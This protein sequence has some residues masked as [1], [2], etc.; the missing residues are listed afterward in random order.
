M[1]RKY[2]CLIVVF[3]YSTAAFS[4]QLETTVVQ[5]GNEKIS[6]EE[7][8]LRFELSPYIPSDRNLDPDSIKYDFLYSLIAEKLWA[9]EAEDIGVTSTDKFNFIFKPLEDMFVRDALFKIE[10][11]DKVSLSAEDI[12]NGNL[13]SQT[14]LNAQI[15]TSNDSLSIFNLYQKLN[16]NINF[17][18]L[19]S[20]TNN[21]TRNIFDVSLG[22]LKD[23]AIEDSLYSLPLNGFTSPIKSEVGWVIFIIKNKIFT[24]IDLGNQQ[25]VDN[26]KKVIRNRRIEKR[27]KEYLNELL[28][29]ITINIDPEAFNLLN[30]KVWNVLKNKSAP[31]DSA[32]YFEISESDFSYIISSLGSDN[33]D[34]QLFILSD[35]EVI[36]KDFLSRLAFNGF[37]VTQLDS[38]VVL[39][40]LNQRVKRFVEEQLITEEAF[41]SGLQHTPQVRNDLQIW[42]ENYLAQLYF[43]NNLDSIKITDND[44]YNYYI[45]ELVNASNIRLLNIRLV[46]INDLDEV[47]NIFDLLKEGKDFGGIV[48]SYG[49][50]DSLVNENGETGLKPLLLLGYV[51]SVASDLELYKIY[52]PIKRNNAYTILQVIERQ[53]SSDTL[54]LSF[55]SIKDQLR[56]DLRFNKLNDR[57]KKITSDLAQQ[58]NVKIYDDVID[59]IQT[60]QIPMFVHRLMGFGGRI[61]GVPLTTPF[62]GWIN[63]EVKKQLLP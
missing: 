14:K 12:T 51:G 6:S 22:S 5:I 52:G 46:S 26:M 27:Y 4:Q 1:I 38:E 62:S 16:E 25:A 24:P 34:R 10:V 45:N 43:N 44:V 59:Q 53:E 8:K 23:E 57:L 13:K 36:L 60:S 50:T 20:K 47:S 2:L 19:V 29:G 21:I 28:G 37:H 3:L 41:K 11:E 33:L 42:K 55:D 9:K 17:D 48:K 40:K 35:K 32:N 31:N 18:S 7:F 39:Q 30:A 61:A 49:R 63:E 56:N 54:K 15:I 58:N